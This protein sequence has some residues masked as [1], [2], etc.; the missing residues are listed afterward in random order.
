MHV[1]DAHAHMHSL[2]L[3]MRAARAARHA[4]DHRRHA[5]LP[6]RAHPFF[7]ARADDNAD[8]ALC[9]GGCACVL[10]VHCVVDRCRLL[11]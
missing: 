5:E 10:E 3:L 7:A 1:S 11:L 6:G 4:G 8:S 9:D 2:D